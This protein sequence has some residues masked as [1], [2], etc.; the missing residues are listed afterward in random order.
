MKTNLFTGIIMLLLS[1][2]PLTSYTQNKTKT[3]NTAVSFGHAPDCAGYSGSCTF[4]STTTKKYANSQ[5]SYNKE[6]NTLTFIFNNKT[7]STNITKLK[8][9]QLEKDFY[10]Y[11]FD[12][13]TILPKE[14]VQQLNIKGNTKIKKGNY[15]VKVKGDDLILTVTLE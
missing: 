5:A 10:L 15:L 12:E 3:I 8:H 4:T 7:N 2:M 14:V 1:I 11:N 13:T 6:N 9:E